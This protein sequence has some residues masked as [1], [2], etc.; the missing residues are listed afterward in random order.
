MKRA[1]PAKHWVIT[2]WENL[3]ENEEKLREYPESPFEQATWQ[4]EKAPHTGRIHIQAYVT[5]KTKQRM[6]K[7]QQ[8]FGAGNHFEVMRGTPEEARKYSSKDESRHQVGGQWGELS[9]ERQGRRTDLA[10]VSE[11][12]RNGKKFKDIIKTHTESAI[13][14]FGNIER[15]YN[16]IHDNKPKPSENFTPRY[17]QNWLSGKLKEQPDERTINWVV[18][19]RGGTGKTKWAKEYLSANPDDVYLTGITKQDRQFF[20]YDGERVVIFD[21]CRAIIPDEGEKNMFPYAQ[22]EHFKNGFFP[23][24]MYG[25]K[26]KHFAVPHV[27]VLANWRPDLAKLS[28]DRWLII[29][30]DDIEWDIQ[31]ELR[32]RHTN[33]DGIREVRFERDDQGPSVP[34]LRRRG[35]FLE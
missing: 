30:L 1:A 4:R 15:V 32:V 31:G 9:T 33:I 18:D 24:G 21:I 7:L 34:T 8:I 29:D 6:A 26:P 16:A 17:W 12:I 22:L 14:Y 25:S 3:D 13:K 28:R 23:A 11:D 10:A 27:V 2:I 5:F 20:A 35:A 19:T